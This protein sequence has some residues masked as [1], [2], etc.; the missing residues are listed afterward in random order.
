[1]KLNQHA[2]ISHRVCR[3]AAIAS[4]DLVLVL[5]VILPLA[6]FLIY[7]LPRMIKLVYEMTITIIG[8]PLM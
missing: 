2:P 7:L 1:M 4:L 6:A 3:R 8:S 5:G